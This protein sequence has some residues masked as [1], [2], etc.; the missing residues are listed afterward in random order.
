MTGI[1]EN[2]LELPCGQVLPNRLCKAAMTE[3]I[4][5]PRNEA[6][7]GHA[8]LYRAWADSGC[9][10]LI[11][12]NVQVDP[13]CLEAPGNIVICGEQRPEHLEAL[14]TYSAAAKA[15]GAKI[16]MQ[17]SH[18]GRQTPKIVNPEPL[19]ASDVQLALPGGQFGKPRA[20]TCDEIRQTIEA[21][22]H[23]AKVAKETGFDGVQ[24]HGA[25][26]YL[27]SQFLSPRSN[28]RTDEWGGPLENRARLLLETV[29][30][31]R[32]AVGRDFGVGVKLN[33]ADFQKGGFSF[34]EC[35][36]V[37]EWLNDTSI[38][39]LE[40]SGGNYEQ[41]KL[42]GIDG[43]QAPE[44]QAVRESSK[45]REAYFVDYAAM[46]R[47]RA[48][49][50]IMATGGFRTLAAMEETVSAGMADMI[51]IGAPL[52]SDPHGV[53]KLLAGEAGRLENYAK[54]MRLGPGFLGPNSKIGMVKM[55][56]A[57]GQMAWNYIAIEAMS[58]GREPPRDIGLLSAYMR[59]AGKQKRQARA[60]IR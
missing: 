38:D 24:V 36:Q 32:A 3:Q 9:G 31:V 15:E 53:K 48:K 30:A 7:E 57:L 46:V 54:T 20:M 59:H 51:G 55:I 1:L 60:L 47:E 19:S 39:L 58:E 5:G 25:H 2:P 23:C 18:A 45:A 43:L 44:E 21:F 41:P 16:W 56:N 28:L 8:V 14:K 49:M 27:I 6:N 13:A 10:L 29:N 22:A 37:V 34:E 42:L 50:P 12:G 52:C 11:T 40:I 35:I 17:I 33:S 4:A 26:G